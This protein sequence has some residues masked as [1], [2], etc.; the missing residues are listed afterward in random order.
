MLK[1]QIFLSKHGKISF[2]ESD[3]MSFFEFKKVLNLLAEHL[4]ESGGDFSDIG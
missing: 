4:K 1:N 3:N 2:S